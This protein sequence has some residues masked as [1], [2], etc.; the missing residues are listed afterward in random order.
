M[1]SFVVISFLS[2][3]ASGRGERATA[4][5]P[6]VFAD[7]KVAEELE[8]IPFEGYEDLWDY[9]AQVEVIMEQLEKCQ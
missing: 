4:C 7:E 2:A 6:P 3:C 9:L 1:L 8:T 5:P